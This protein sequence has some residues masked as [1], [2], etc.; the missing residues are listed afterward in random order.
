MTDQEALMK[1]VEGLREAIELHNY[2]YYV[3]DDPVI[4]DAEYDSLFRE[5]QQL[6]GTHPALATPDSPTKRVG[7]KALSEFPPV[8]HRVP[9]LSLNN[10]FSEEE[11]AAFD[12]RV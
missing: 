6:E 2:R 1:R 4:S 3:L 8:S 9:M 5:L 12:R 10:A 11:V 7:A